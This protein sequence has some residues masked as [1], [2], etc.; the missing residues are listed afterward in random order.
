VTQS[1]QKVYFRSNN[2]HHAQIMHTREMT[3]FKQKQTNSSL[4]GGESLTIGPSAVN[5][6]THIYIRVTVK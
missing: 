5:I 3:Q 2:A 4:D 6:H 1:K